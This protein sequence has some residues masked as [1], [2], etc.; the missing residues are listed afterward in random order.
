MT[1]PRRYRTLAGFIRK[2]LTQALRDP[3]AVSAPL[4][5]TVFSSQS[6]R[7]ISPPPNVPATVIVLF[8]HESESCDAD[9]PPPNT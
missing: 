9:V 3:H 7:R 4:R 6:M 5:E 8:P 2:E 1:L